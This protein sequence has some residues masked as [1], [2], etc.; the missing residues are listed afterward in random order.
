MEKLSDI[1]ILGLKLERE[2]RSK[3]IQSPH[4]AL[5]QS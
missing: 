1:H 3:N 5:L 4:L 2:A